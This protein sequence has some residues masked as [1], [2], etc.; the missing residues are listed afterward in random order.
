M[1]K[2]STHKDAEIKLTSPGNLP[3]GFTIIIK[4]ATNKQCSFE[5]TGNDVFT[6]NLKT[7]TYAI[8]ER[9]HSAYLNLFE[10]LAKDFG[11]SIPQNREKEIQYNS[12]IKYHELLSKNIVGEM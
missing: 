9:D 5:V 1:Q 6:N 11:L 10:K 7:I 2:G 4:E 3:F 8:T 12:E